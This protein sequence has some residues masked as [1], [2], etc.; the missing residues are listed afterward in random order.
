MTRFELAT[1][2]LATSRSN[3]LSYICM[4]DMV[5]GV[6][7]RLL[8]TGIKALRLLT[9]KG[10]LLRGANHTNRVSHPDQALGPSRLATPRR[11]SNSPC[12]LPPQGERPS[13][14]WDSNP[15]PSPYHGDAPPS[16]LQGQVTSCEERD[17]VPATP[18]PN[19]QFGYMRH[20]SSVPQVR[21]ELTPGRLLKTVPLPLGYQGINHHAGAGRFELPPTGTKIRRPT[22]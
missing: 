21:L 20:L 16:E 10:L 2:T 1:S 6:R 14:R 22:D 13:P 15:Q 9:E 19:D 11:G 7:L 12:G 18:S 3:Q 4:N 17:E 5:L 8:W